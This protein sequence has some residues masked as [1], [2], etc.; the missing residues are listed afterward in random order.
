MM[1]INNRNFTRDE[2]YQIYQNVNDKI[3]IERGRKTQAHP[4]ASIINRTPRANSAFAE[5]VY[6]NNNQN[7]GTGQRNSSYP[8]A[9]VETDNSRV[10]IERDY[11]SNEN[12]KEII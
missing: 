9:P 4:L 2:N 3:D 10:S 7:S 8:I 12:G 6:E 1:K 5:K 11:N